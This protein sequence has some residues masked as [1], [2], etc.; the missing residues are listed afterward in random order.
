[1]KKLLLIITLMS[2]A[3]WSQAQAIPN[4]G[5][6]TWENVGGWYLDPEGWETNNSHIMT[7]VLP[8]TNSYSG[9]YSLTISHKYSGI[10]GYAKS[11]FPFNAHAAAIKA[12]VKC[13]MSETDTVS[14][15]VDIYSNRQITGN[16]KW[17][18]AASISEWTLISIPLTQKSSDGDS[19]EIQ[20]F[21][22]DSSQTSISLDEF[23]YDIISGIGAHG[24]PVWTLYPNP[25]NE[26]LNYEL[27]WLD[28]NQLILFEITDIY[29]RTVARVDKYS[30][31]GELRLPD[32]PSG[33]YIVKIT[34]NKEVLTKIVIRN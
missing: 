13:E 30:N 20:I 27:P 15:L 33:A 24:S 5:F 4:S 28:D 6:E 29:G 14:V 9:N 18:S 17:T 19:L 7:P 23:S 3:F 31:H 10:T 25:F 16:G 34:T 12:Y 8:D 21:G 2:A 26:K 22:G 1:M 32:I 11:R